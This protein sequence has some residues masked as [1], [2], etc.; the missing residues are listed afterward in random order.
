MASILEKKTNLV[1]ASHERTEKE[2]GKRRY[3]TVE[4]TRP[5]KYSPLFHGFLK[6]KKEVLSP[7]KEPDK[8]NVHK[9]HRFGSSLAV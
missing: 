5:R 7:L 4:T 1:V 2:K 9:I 3:K 8:Y 6:R